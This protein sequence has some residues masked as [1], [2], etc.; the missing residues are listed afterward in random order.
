MNG[1]VHPAACAA[2]R[3]IC[4]APGRL[5]VAGLSNQLGLSVRRLEQVFRAD[6]GLSP[7]AYQRLQRFRSALSRIDSVP[8]CGWAEIATESGYYD[9]SHLIHDFQHHAGLTPREY[10]KARGPF[11]NHVPISA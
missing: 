3:R 2:A 6:V 4:A 1:P 8:A 7:K 5:S 10:L 11:L 9:Q